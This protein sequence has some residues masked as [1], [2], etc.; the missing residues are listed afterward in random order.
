MAAV[1]VRV[2]SAFPGWI[3]FALFGLWTLAV[4]LEIPLIVH[5]WSSKPP[6]A[7]ERR[8]YLAYAIGLPCCFAPLAAWTAVALMVL[9]E[10]VETQF[11]RDLSVLV[12]LPA[13]PIIATSV[14]LLPISL[15]VYPG[16]I[17]DL[18][19]FLVRVLSLVNLVTPYLVATL[20]Y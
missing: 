7:A 17:K 8:R 1:A 13:V 19:F 10:A 4:A 11:F 3:E 18:G 20:M 2:L 9:G 15:A 6:R 14:I 12:L 5:L 16:L